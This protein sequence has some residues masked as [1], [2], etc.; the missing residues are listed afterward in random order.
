M[1]YPVFAQRIAED[2]AFVQY[3]ED[4]NNKVWETDLAD[5]EYCYKEIQDWAKKLRNILS[6]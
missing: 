2:E 4:H 3:V 5:W 1:T 6:I